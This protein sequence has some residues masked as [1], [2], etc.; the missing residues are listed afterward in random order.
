MHLGFDVYIPKSAYDSVLVISKTIPQLIK[1]LALAVYG[2]KVL[3]ESTVTGTASN[4]KKNEN[5]QSRPALDPTK[6]KAIRGNI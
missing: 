2:I 4:R 5:V 1:N 6:L 3:K